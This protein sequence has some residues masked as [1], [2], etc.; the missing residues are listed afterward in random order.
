MVYAGKARPARGGF[1]PRPDLNTNYKPMPPMPIESPQTSLTRICDNRVRMIRY[2][3]VRRHPAYIELLREDL[4]KQIRYWMSEA[5][6]DDHQWYNDLF[7]LVK[8]IDLANPQTLRNVYLH[9]DKPY[10]AIV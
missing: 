10:P 3:N 9:I 1:A 5:H 4:N 8:A 2:W 7:G 6:I